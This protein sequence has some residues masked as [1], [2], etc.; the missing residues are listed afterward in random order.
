MLLVVAQHGMLPKIRESKHPKLWE[1]IV[2]IF[3]S[4]RTHSTLQDHLI[5]MLRLVSSVIMKSASEKKYI[6]KELYF[7]LQR[8]G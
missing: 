3:G 6:L 2:L 8:S 4:I 7:L 5:E 1:T